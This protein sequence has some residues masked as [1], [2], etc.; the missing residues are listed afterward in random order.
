MR[1]RLVA[2]SATLLL[3]PALLAGC[4]GDDPSPAAA[5]AGTDTRGCVSSFDENTDY[6]PVHSTLEYAKNFTITYEKA[7]QVVTVKEPYPDGK[8]ESYVLYRCG[9]PK[10]ELTGD[11]ADAP[12]VETPITSLYS[13]STTHLPL[14][15]DLGRLDVLTGVATGTYVINKEV[16][17]LVDAGKVVEYATNGQIDT[18]RVVTG[19]PDVLMTDGYDVPEFQKLRDAGVPVVA[20]AEWL[21]GDPLGRAEWVKFM[22][23]FTGDED[24]ATKAF[25]KIEADYDAIAAKVPDEKAV[26]VLVGSMYQGTWY[27]PSGG[28]YVAKLLADAGA[29]YPW[30]DSTDAGS[31][32]LDFE[33]VFTKA[34]SAKIWLAD[35]EWKSLGDITGEDARYGQLTAVR[36]GQVWDNNLVTNAD[37][38]N[39]YRE[40]GVARPDLVLG[41]LAAI[42]H[43]DAFPNHTFAFYQQLK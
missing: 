14:L 16:R 23:A 5:G 38:G 31:L 4:G 40:R 13:G 3:I 21:E 32:E 30:A 11:L 6:F 39:D 22:A 10:P 1:A 18:E 25:D 12:R 28:S 20:N 35:G 42:L 37:G 7:Y 19:A 29:S 15:A 8:P 27:M 9:T 36:D 33:T 41:D 17:G 26:P 43:P 2:L 24:K 34:G